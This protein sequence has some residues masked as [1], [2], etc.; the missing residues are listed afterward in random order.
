MQQHSDGSRMIGSH[1]FA[2]SMVAGFSTGIPTLPAGWRIVPPDLRRRLDDHHR[3][4]KS[5]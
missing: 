4:D 3:M 5:T 1:T 2:H